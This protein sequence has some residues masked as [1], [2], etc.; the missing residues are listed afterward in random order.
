MNSVHPSI[1]TGHIGLDDKD[2]RCLPWCSIPFGP[3]HERLE[4]RVLI[5]ESITVV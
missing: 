2:D 4:V 1:L 5:I 3:V